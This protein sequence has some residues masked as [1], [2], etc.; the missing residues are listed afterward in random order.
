MS[1][2]KCF[3][4][5]AFAYSF[6]P[7]RRKLDDKAK[8]GVF[9]GYDSNS[10]AYRIYLANERK[11]IKSGHVVFNERGIMNWGLEIQ[12]ALDGDWYLGLDKNGRSQ[13]DEYGVNIIREAHVQP[14]IN[15][16]QP[17]IDL[18]DNVD[19][20]MQTRGI[21]RDYRALHNGITTNRAGGERAH[22][23]RETILHAI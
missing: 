13:V 19:T 9:V 7:N 14:I 4:C 12:G 20:H 11:I 22:S 18:S 15:N 3:G 6:D 16:E 17:V 5:K 23:V 8:A 21:K 10:A 1:H 2:L